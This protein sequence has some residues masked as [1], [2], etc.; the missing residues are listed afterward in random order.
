[1]QKADLDWKNLPFGYIR[2]DYNIRY[3]Y[4]DGAWS[5]GELTGDTSVQMHIAD[6]CLH[7]GQ[8]AFEG[9]KAFET[10]DGRIVVFRPIEN[11]RR[12]QVSS[13]RIL[14]PRMPVEMFLDGIRRVV[15]ANARFVP[16]YGT[17]ASLYIRP[18]VFGVSPQIGLGPAKEYEFIILVTPVGPYYKGGFTPVKALIVD[19]YDRAAPLGMGA[20][21]VG[22]NYAAGLL[23]YEYAHQ[24]G[25]P[26]ALYLDPKE[27]K[28]IDEFGTSNFIGIIGNTYIT[29]KSSSILPSITNDSLAIIAADMGMT[30]ERRPIDVEELSG[31]D[32]VGAVGT[33]AVITPI[34]SV[35]Y[36]DRTFTFGDGATAGP[37][38]TKLYEKLTSIQKGEIQDTFGFLDDVKV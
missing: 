18:V 36:K 14:V 5:A 19:E 10:K 33:A 28:Y 7:Y 32:E 4:K 29:P 9:L 11:A 31:F 26:I 1:M 17:G 8:E 2:T 34:A 15:A 27:K 30:I 16:P 12:M 20:Y 25:Y 6:P 3:H 24:K 22:A 23:G 37:I 38:S 35:Q 21:K 13:D